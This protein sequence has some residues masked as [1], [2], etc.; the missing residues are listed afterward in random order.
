MTNI[1]DLF[2]AQVDFSYIEM[3]LHLEYY[4]RTFAQWKCLTF[5]CELPCE[6]ARDQHLVLLLMSLNGPHPVHQLLKTMVCLS[7]HL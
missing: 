2:R 1:A 4:G 6:A 5:I 3:H 7:R